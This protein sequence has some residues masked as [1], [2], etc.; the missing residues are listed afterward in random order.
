MDLAISDYS[1]A[2]AINPDY[3]DAYA[4]RGII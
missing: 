1:K 4:E 3:A 2:I